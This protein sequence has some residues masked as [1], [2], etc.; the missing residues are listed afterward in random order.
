[1]A[2]FP[3]VATARDLGLSERGWRKI[4]KGDVTTLAETAER[5]GL[6]ADMRRGQQRP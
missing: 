1:L 5:I 2:Q 3:Q 6:V 4:I